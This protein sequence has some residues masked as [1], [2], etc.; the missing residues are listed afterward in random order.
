[1]KKGNLSEK[2]CFGGERVVETIKIGGFEHVHLKTMKMPRFYTRNSSE[3]LDS[4]A[5]QKLNGLDCE[6]FRKLS[7]LVSKAV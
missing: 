1:V 4:K 6:E 3:R 2:L 5:M 7:S